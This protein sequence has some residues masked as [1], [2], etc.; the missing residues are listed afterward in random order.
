MSSPPDVPL[1]SRA[2]GQ[3]Q[4]QQHEA[5]AP[6]ELEIVES[7]QATSDNESPLFV[8]QTSAQGSQ[9]PREPQAAVYVDAPPLSF[10]E[11][12]YGKYSSSEHPTSSA[13]A[14]AVSEGLPTAPSQPQ[15]S[16]T[17]VETPQ[18]QVQSVPV[19]FGGRSAKVVPDSQGLQEW[20]SSASTTSSKKP[21]SGVQAVIQGEIPSSAPAPLVS[22]EIQSQPLAQAHSQNGQPLADLTQTYLTSEPVEQSQSSQESSAPVELQATDGRASVV[23]TNPSV[24][25]ASSPNKLEAEKNTAESST[26]SAPKEQAQQPHR[27]GTGSRTLA[28]ARRLRVESASASAAPSSFPFLTQIQP[29][30]LIT[31]QSQRS[32]LIPSQIR[33]LHTLTPR[34]TSLPVGSTPIASVPSRSIGSLVFGDSAPPRPATPSSPSTVGA[35]SGIQSMEASP[36]PVNAK[37]EEI[38]ARIRAKREQ[39]RSASRESSL[40][41]PP[42]QQQAPSSN[43]PNSSVVPVTQS[44]R[45]ASLS[46]AFNDRRSPSAVP[47]MEPLTM[48]TQKEMNT[49]ERFETLLP[50]SSQKQAGETEMNG[51]LTGAATPHEV[52]RRSVEHRDHVVAIGFMGHQA[53]QYRQV[54]YQ[55]TI[56]VQRYL[57]ESNPDEDLTAEAERFVEKMRRYTLHPDLDNAEALTQYDVQPAHRAQWDVDCSAKF[58]FLRDLLESLKG[59]TLRI[60]IMTKT[61]SV[62]DIL[63][64]FLTGIK[65]RHAR[66]S[67]SDGFSGADQDGLSVSVLLEPE[68]SPDLLRSADLLVSLDLVQISTLATSVRCPTVRLIVPNTVEHIDY[69]LS[70]TLSRRA[71]LRALISGIYQLRRDAG[72][73]EED[74]L[75]LDMA[76]HGIAR[77]LGGDSQ[78]DWPLPELHPLDGLDSQTES[79]IE[80]T[81]GSASQAV[82]DNQSGHKRAFDEDKADMDMP[83][84]SKKAR[85]DATDLPLTINPQE[86]DATHISDSVNKATQSSSTGQHAHS[87]GLSDVEQRLQQLLREAQDRA[88]ELSKALSDLQYRHEEQREQ[89]IERSNQR[90]AAI[91]TAQQAVTRMTETATSLSTVKAERTELREKL[92]EAKVRLL[93]HIVP[94]R[95]ELELYKQKAAEAQAE[96]A[97]LEK[98]LENAKRDLEYSQA[99]YQTASNGAQTFASQNADLENQLAVTQNRA[100]GEQ[101]RLRQMGYDAQTLSMRDENKKLKAMLRDRDA[102]LKFRDEE[103]ARLK[104]AQRGRMGTR[105]TSVPRSPRLGSPMKLDGRR[106]NGSRQVSPAA[107]EPRIKAGHLHPLKNG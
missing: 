41:S 79:E 37:T 91:S 8:T 21:S 38:R 83:L 85:V 61:G 78:D 35:L 90:D 65:V 89:L 63:E 28:I 9:S 100:T 6:A 27:P 47:H 23:L 1:S 95:A 57:E 17:V 3:G 46:A 44:P 59:Q 56:V 87:S 13:I 40:T 24:A 32:P 4:H 29:S 62:V 64:T 77:Y 45:L 68:L 84:P 98:R 97:K 42:Q 34:A 75:A 72:Q 49:S 103:I 30:G 39:N 73:L 12:A 107:G 11:G 19:N 16:Q 31:A 14:A 96:T 71:R 67:Q 36:R 60:V 50:Q 80:H 92:K 93:D 106:G 43:S 48:L 52:P 53:D 20:S 101:A 94:E 105:G 10:A 22:G 25:A 26:Q 88:D 5:E 74:Q 76:A 33:T 18:G 2:N 54:V 81:S 70:P 69:S 86:I 99:S 82:A 7:Q 55:N 104:E 58:R 15:R 66:P 51:S 102:G